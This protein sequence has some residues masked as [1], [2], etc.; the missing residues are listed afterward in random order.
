MKR[1]TLSQRLALVFAGLLLGCT[2]LSGL[3]QIHINRQYSSVVIQRL[4]AGLAGHMV[5]R[6]GDMIL[7]KGTDLPVLQAMF[8]D[9]MILN[10]RVEVYLIDSSGN[11]LNDTIPPGR[12]KRNRIDI[13]PIQAFLNGTALPVYGDD[14]RFLPKKKV[15]SVAPV[16]R[17]GAICGYLYVILQ[18]ANYHLLAQKAQLDTFL[19]TSI[20]SSLLVVLFGLTA[21]AVAFSLVTR[22]VRQ[23]TQRVRKLSSKEM[24]E[25]QSMAKLPL[26]PPGEKDE[27]SLLQG[28]FVS[29]ARHI[30]FQW[31]KLAYQDQLRREFVANISH[32]LRTPLTTL[33]GYLETLLYKSHSLKAEQGQH[34][35]HIALSQSQKVSTLAQQLF[36]LAQLEYGVIKP[37]CEVFSLPE[38]T[39][40]VLQKFELMIDA[41]KIRVESDINENLPQV[42]ADISMMD[43]VLTNL[44]DNAIKHTPVAGTIAIGLCQTER[45]IEVCIKDSG[46]GISDAQRATLFERPSALSH[47]STGTNSGGL[48]LM[49]VRRILQLHQSDISL[50]EGSGGACFRFSV[51]RQA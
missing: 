6:Y 38:L 9:F 23:L 7:E 17:N 18:G 2:L 30:A 20:W 22:P 46:P 33:H 34:Y 15:F 25:I 37:N 32:D 43:R 3:M 21:G 16:M 1:L 48:G 39:Y 10:P 8:N 4:N 13:K 28:A 36:E 14:P 29:M 42:H 11:I 41:K 19:Y 49:V 31:E 12:L 47:A 24:A 26:P 51:P 5:N 40:D 44:L 50:D 45:A 27:V 35:L